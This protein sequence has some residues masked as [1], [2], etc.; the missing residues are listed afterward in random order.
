MHLYPSDIPKFTF[1]KGWLTAECWR[2]IIWGGEVYWGGGGLDP[3][4]LFASQGCMK[5][6]ILYDTIPARL[7]KKQRRESVWNGS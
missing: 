2:E 5:E 7:A 3:Q 4:F 1:T 6:W